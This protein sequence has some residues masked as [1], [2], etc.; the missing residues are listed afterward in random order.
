V[1]DVWRDVFAWGVLCIPKDIRPGEKRPVVIC[2]HGLEGTPYH[3][4]DTSGRAYEGYKSFAARLAAHGFV[5]FAPHNPYR[6][7]NEFRS[8]QRK[9]NP[10]KASL[11]SIITPQH[12]Q[13]LNWLETLPFVDKNRIGFYG[14]S[15]GGKSAM[16]IPAIENRY[17][18]SICSADF[19]EWVRIN[20]DIHFPTAYMYRGEEYEMPEWDLGHAFNYAEMAYLIAP[21]P[22]M[23]ERGHSDGVGIDPWIAYEF[24]RAHRVYDCLGISDKCLIEYF[25]GPHTIHG[26]GTFE[27]LRR[28]LGFSE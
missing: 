9:A 17:Q 5:T 20:A 13:I 10:L 12:S 11:F 24:D 22:F 18:L 15:Y 23:V 2:Q 16:R 27:F 19:N 8:M 7:H 25:D 1:V 3:T 6:G 28:E 4:I 14:L 26:V 21:R